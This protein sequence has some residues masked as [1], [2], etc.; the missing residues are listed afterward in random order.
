[1]GSAA[2][3]FWS[4]PSPLRSRA[5]H[6]NVNAY[7]PLGASRK[8]AGSGTLARRER[9]A[10]G[11]RFDGTYCSTH[12]RAPPEA[13]VPRTWHDGY[14]EN[15]QQFQALLRKYDNDFQKAVNAW[16]REKSAI[17]A[18]VGAGQ[19]RCDRVVARQPR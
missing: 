9:N 6:R 11:R 3:L 5:R 13:P 2:V 15:T 14:I 18:R 4:T 16:L 19:S 12:D 7:L 10:V 8:Q 17:H 1:M